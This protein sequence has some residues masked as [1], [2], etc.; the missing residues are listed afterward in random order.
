MSSS[1][2]MREEEEEEETEGIITILI[3]VNGWTAGCG[4]NRGEDGTVR[5]I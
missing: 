4:R 2:I 5:G 1:I 3:L